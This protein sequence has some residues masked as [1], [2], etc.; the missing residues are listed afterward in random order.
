MR[1]Y[2]FS[3]M[4]AAIAVCG[5]GTY[6]SIGRQ[7]QL[8]EYKL[9]TVQGD[10][11]EGAAVILSGSHYGNMRSNAL[12]VSLEGSK[13]SFRNENFRKG[14]L[15]A[16]SY[17][18]KNP[19][20]QQ[21]LNDHKSFMRSKGNSNGF[22]RDKE[23][24]IYADMHAG[25]GR[26]NASNGYLQLSF[27]YE[28]TGKVIDFKQ[29]NLDQQ[30]NVSLYVEDVQRV[31]D[32]VHILFRKYSNTNITEYVVYVFNIKT[33]EQLRHSDV[34]RV[35]ADGQ[36]V[37][38]DVSLIRTDSIT[39]A[40][41][42]IYFVERATS[43]LVEI[44]GF[45]SYSYRSGLFTPLSE[46]LR[47]PSEVEFVSESLQNDLFYYAEASSDQVT[48]SRYDTVTKERKQAYAALSAA[49]LGADEI[50]RVL[51]NSNRVYLLLN[52]A[53]NSGAAVLDIETGELL[54]T[55]FAAEVGEDKQTEEELRE[56]LHLINLIIDENKK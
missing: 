33:A 7:N 49:Q 35:S 25:S 16:N 27:L 34:N 5:I 41:D 55:G 8:P 3:I 11:K 19:E 23:M 29:I 42:T 44:G 48:L 28:E 47:Y 56:N 21:L 26:S 18:Y 39:D 38:P 22:Y 6:Y 13:Y 9:E 14:I 4:I 32:E 30:G 17:F 10:A 15:E 24:V 40:N 36:V 52:K 2:W 50:K 12:D 37:T 45:Y 53:G 31:D 51:I 54:F 46:P 1:R 20:I 43:T